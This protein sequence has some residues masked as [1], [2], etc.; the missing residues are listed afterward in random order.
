MK[1][2]KKKRNKYLKRFELINF[3][4]SYQLNF[5]FKKIKN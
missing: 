2:M 5:Y 1:K 3:L 4:K